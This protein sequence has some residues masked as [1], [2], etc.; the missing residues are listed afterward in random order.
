MD[1]NITFFVQIINFGITYFFLNKILFRPVVHF[2]QK[3]EM[4]KQ[5]LINKI[6]E[7][8]HEL[9]TLY[10]QKASDMLNFQSYVAKKY[11]L[12]KFIPQ[13]IPLQVRYQK[14]IRALDSLVQRGSE[15]VLKEIGHACKS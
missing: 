8:E 3:R 15:L 2:L 7:K 4:L 12:T 13:E 6:S 5:R 1:I 14:D 10:S 9:D 11:R